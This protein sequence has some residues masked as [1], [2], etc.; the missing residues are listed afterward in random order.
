MNF[1]HN[2]WQ[3]TPITPVFDFEKNQE[4]PTIRPDV[5]RELL[6][7]F[8][9][10][11]NNAAKYANASIIHLTL[12]IVEKEYYLMEIKDNG[13]GFDPLSIDEKNGHTKG[14]SGMKKRAENIH[15]H[16][17]ID[18]KPNEGTIVRLKGKF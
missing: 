1:A 2:F 5:K 15:A 7:I 3:N 6:L 16:F 9:E 11:Q 13:K 12:K 8:K 4:N 18:S 14:V 10:A 17:E